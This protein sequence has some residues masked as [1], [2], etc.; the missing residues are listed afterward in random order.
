M[1]R[2]IIGL[3]IATTV[4]CP[5]QDAAKTPSPEEIL[6]I[7]IKCYMEISALEKE[8]S[9]AVGNRRYTYDAYYSVI[10]LLKN[11]KDPKEDLAT[12]NKQIADNEKQLAEAKKRNPNSPSIRYAEQS[13]FESQLKKRIL[14]AKD[15]AAKVALLKELQDKQKA[16]KAEM[17]LASKPFNDKIAGLREKAKPH[18]D[19]FKAILTKY[20][21]QPE[22]A[23]PGSKISFQGTI[24][25]GFASVNWNDADGK[26]VAW[27]HWRIRPL[28]DAK[29]VHS[30]DK[31][32]GKYVISSLSDGSIWIWAGP[33]NICFVA[34][35][36][37][38]KGK[39]N[40]KAKIKDFID[41]ES[42]GKLVPSE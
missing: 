18:A 3:L 9:K 20:A 8:S 28:A 19:A 31:L 6:A 24:H 17:D 22:K 40:L 29:K 35:N 11:K 21:L 1:K 5:A 30:T 2:L 39:E 37:T 32:D 15:D 33:V 23:F 41:L 38:L 10:R 4:M 26:Q 36:D 34:S 7:S 13:L 12:L 27:S 16:L 25:N 14:E 42:L